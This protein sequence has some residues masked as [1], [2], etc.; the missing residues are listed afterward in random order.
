[1]AELWAIR[2]DKTWIAEQVGRSV[3]TVHRDCMELG[4]TAMPFVPQETRNIL[5]EMDTAPEFIAGCAIELMEEWKERARGSDRAVRAFVAL[6][7]LYAKVAGAYAPEKRL[8]ANVNIKPPEPVRVPMQVLEQTGDIIGEL[9]I[10][11][12]D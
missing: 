12:R 5:A 11:D 7:D 9:Q 2:P 10:D 8:N 3:S 4:L 6:A 1:M